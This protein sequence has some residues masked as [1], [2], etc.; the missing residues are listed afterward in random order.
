MGN[1]PGIVMPSYYVV[2]ADRKRVSLSQAAK[3]GS[4]NAGSG[5]FVQTH[6]SKQSWSFFFWQNGNT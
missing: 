3:Y 2:A 4:S 5:V 1:S 6:V